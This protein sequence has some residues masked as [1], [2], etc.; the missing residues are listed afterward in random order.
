MVLQEKS[1]Q[2][3]VKAA[4]LIAGIAGLSVSNPAIAAPLFQAAPD[5]T[6]AEPDQSGD[7]IINTEEDQADA[8]TPEPSAEPSATTTTSNNRFS[9]QAMNGE[10]MVMYN[11]ES[12][13]GKL[14]PWAKPTAMGGGWSAE[15]RCMEISRRLEAYRPDGLL[16]MKT[17]IENG[18]NVVC[19]TTQKISD[20]RIVLTVPQG[21]SAMQTRDRVFDN[22]SV[23]DRGVETSAVNTFV[24]GNDALGQ[25]GQLLNGLPRI[26][27]RRDRSVDSGIN[28][29]P[30]LDRADGGTGKFLRGNGN[31]ATPGL[32]LNPDQFR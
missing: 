8:P 12:Q 29:R 30:Y 13:P 11:P 17:N 18:Y 2:G 4:L 16:E 32:R 10:Y 22:L 28:L 24:G 7:V 5:S 21:Q 6:S 15:R 9:C 31:S 26:G 1:L 27:S 19:V 14:Y 23:A 3:M 20:C 25:V